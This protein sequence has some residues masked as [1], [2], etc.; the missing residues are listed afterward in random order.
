MFPGACLSGKLG[1]EFSYLDLMQ[2]NIQHVNCPKLIVFPS[3]CRRQ[4]S[5]PSSPDAHLKPKMVY[6]LKQKSSAIG[7][8][9]IFQYACKEHICCEM[10]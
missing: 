6:N 8:K 10:L 9:D 4:N 2:I 1:A 7:K 3:K 5:V